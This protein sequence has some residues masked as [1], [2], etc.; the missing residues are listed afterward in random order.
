M[1]TTLFTGSYCAEDV[2]FLL[3]PMDVQDT[4]IHIKEALIQ[5]GGKHYSEL[6][7]HEKLPSAEYLTLFHQAMALN[8]HR[9]AQDVVCLAEQ[10]VATRKQGITVVSLAR[11][12]TP[13]GV[14]LKQLLKRRYNM[15]VPHYS[16]SILRDVGLDTNALRYIL[17]HHA[18]ESLVFVDGWTGKGVIAQQLADSLLAFAAS[19]GIAIA[20]ELYVL[21]DLS[22]TAAVAAGYDDYLIPSCILNATVSGL[23]SRTVYN[24]DPAQ[25]DDFH[26][27]VYY[28][29]Y[30]AH[31]YSRYFIDT[32]LAAIDSPVGDAPSYNAVT[33]PTIQHAI[34]KDFLLEIARCYAV[35]HPHYIK[36]GI[37]EATRVLLRRKARLLLLRELTNASTQHLRWLANSKAIPIAIRSDLP[38]Q[39]AALIEEV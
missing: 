26:G 5:S 38:Y 20:A 24:K 22:G 27:C 6:L 39:A 10:I 32:V 15:E 17:Q 4:P 31:D 34:A 7:S 18:A 25:A 28:A 11:A 2:Y 3:Q 13:I 8:K 16:V 30:K 1:S 9:V 33:K 19:D 14:L 21:T 37:G 36:P 12:G 23:I 35:S 29:H